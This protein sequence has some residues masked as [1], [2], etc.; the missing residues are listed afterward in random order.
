VTTA[1]A[2]IGVGLPILFALDSD[3]L[4]P[5]VKRAQAVVRHLV[6]RH[7]LAEDRFVVRGVGCAQLLLP[8][9]GKNER[10]RRVQVLRVDS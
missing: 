7:G 8:T 1:P 5:S 3:V 4:T 9:D 10:N 6:Q 2:A